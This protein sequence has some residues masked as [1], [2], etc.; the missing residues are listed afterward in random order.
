MSKITEDHKA[1]LKNLEEW[2]VTNI[3]AAAPYLQQQFPYL[4]LVECRAILGD[5]L[6]TKNQLL[7][8]AH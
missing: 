4:T 2:G 1:F 6:K 3:D 7:N 8:E 5:W